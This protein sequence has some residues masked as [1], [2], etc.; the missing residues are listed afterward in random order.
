MAVPR[1][2]SLTGSG[3]LRME[4]IAEIDN[5]RRRHRR[6][7]EITVSPGEEIGLEG[8]GNDVLEISAVIEPV[9]AHECGLAIRY[10]SD[11][12]EQTLVSYTVAEHRI[13]V[14]V[15]RS[16]Q[17][18]DVVDFEEQ[19]APLTLGGNEPLRLRIFLDRSVIEVFAN[20]RSC[21]AKRIYPRSFEGVDVSLFAR[22]GTAKLV[23]LDAWD[24]EPIW[25]HQ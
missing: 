18:P 11:G 22:G 23:S 4:P 10:S 9:S 16:S 8:I 13:K 17:N 19:A 1:V 25:P 6:V 3:A 2:L 24:M 5:L 15:S 20:D 7:A 21:L 14:D 12:A